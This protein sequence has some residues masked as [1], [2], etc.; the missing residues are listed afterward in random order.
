MDDQR[1]PVPETFT[2][3]A[4]AEFLRRA[5]QAGYDVYYASEAFA[6]EVV[7]APHDRVPFRDDAW[8][9]DFFS[10]HRKALT[11]YLRGI[12]DRTEMDRQLFDEPSGR[13]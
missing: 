2:E 8:L 1:Q 3:E 6:V 5:M 13:P 7:V 12:D 11:I 4:G 10:K 9:D